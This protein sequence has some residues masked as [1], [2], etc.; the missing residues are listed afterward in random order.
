MLDSMSLS[1]NKIENQSAKYQNIPP[2]WFDNTADQDKADGKIHTSTSEFEEVSQNRTTNLPDDLFRETI[3]KRLPEDNWS[4]TTTAVSIERI[5]VDEDKNAVSHLLPNI[6][7]IQQ[8]NSSNSTPIATKLRKVETEP[9]RKY[10]DQ[11]EEQDDTGTWEL[12]DKAFNT[13]VESSRNQPYKRSNRIASGTKMNIR[14]SRK[15]AGIEL[16]AGRQYRRLF[17]LGPKQRL[18]EDSKYQ[19]LDL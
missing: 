19:G 12:I 2:S 10:E 13:S 18:D 8:R 3:M 17:G 9:S 1:A 15:H 5:S 11:T 4:S 16:D 7:K 6:L 14:K